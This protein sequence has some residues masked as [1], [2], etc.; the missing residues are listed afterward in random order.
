[1]L[2]EFL[3]FLKQYGVVGL[4]IAV[5]IGGKL[6]PSSAASSRTSSCLSWAC[7]SRVGNGASWR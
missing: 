1:M 4:A 5:V 3:G 2:R 6:T 7:S